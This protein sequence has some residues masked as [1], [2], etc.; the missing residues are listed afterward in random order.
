MNGERLYTKAEVE[1]IV[2]K[3]MDREKRKIGRE[4]QQKQER[5]ENE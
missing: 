1:S 4:Q 5:N 3:R 2:K